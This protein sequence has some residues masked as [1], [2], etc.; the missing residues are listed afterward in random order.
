MKESNPPRLFVRFFRWFCHPE[1][2]DYVEGDLM[3]VYYRRRANAG[4]RKADFRFMIDVLLLLRP[5]IIR[6]MTDFRHLNTYSMYKSYFK[7]GWRNLMR[8]KGYALINIGGLSIG[9]TV[10]MLI[11]LWIWDEVSFDSFFDNRD[12]LA[13]VMINQS[14]EGIVYTG[15][16]IQMPLG[17]ALRTGY[18]SDFTG[19]SLA[20]WN[21]QF[22]LS[23]GETKLSGKGMWVQDEFPRMFTF[24]MLRGSYEALKDP[25]TVL[26][27]SSLARALFGN[28]D[29]VNRSLRVDS[30]MDLVVGGV[31]EDLP[32]NTT[33]HET[34]LLLPWENK[35]NWLN[36]QTDW[37]N[38]CGQLFVELRS[39]ADF[40]AVNEKIKGVPTPHI[41]KWKEE[42]MLHPMSKVHLYNHFEN[43]KAAG[44]RIQFI[45]LFGIIGVFVLL[46]ACIN[47]MNLSTARSERRAKEV[48]VRKTIGSV[49]SQIIGQFLCESIVVAG[50]AFVISLML[51]E[52][53]L[54][55]F[56]IQADKRMVVPWD[57]P[58]FWLLALGFTFSTGLIS[59]SYPAFYLSAFKP[60]KILKGVFT[61]GR[62]ALPRK[63]LVV[64]QF[65]VSITL[66]IGTLI[67]FRQVQHAKNRM[68][69][70]ARDGVI[71]VGI[72]TEELR[73]STAVIRN[74]LLQQ[75][76][77]E[78]MA[79]S[80]QSPA[81]FGNNNGI[82]WRGK[83][84]GLVVFFRNVGVDADFGKTIG[85]TVKRGRDFSATLPGD[86][87]AMVINERAAKVMGFED[88]L[89]E[90]VKF[91]G[92]EYTIIGVTQDMLTQSPYDPSEPT[93]F[94][95]DDWM[96]LI[97]MRLD[98]R[99][100]VGEA[101]AGIET[102]FKKY[103][104]ESP[105]DFSFVD[106][107]YARKY[108][109]EE[110]IGNLTGLFAALAIFISCLG[111]SGL[112]SFV[113]EQRT[114]EIGIR[115]VLGASA[116]SL[117]KMLSADFVILTIIAC[118]I[119]I[120]LSFAFMNS[121]LAQY[122]YRIALSWE[123]FTAPALGAVILTLMT[124]SYQ[125][126]KAVVANPV[127]SLRSE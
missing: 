10:A 1:I 36:T 64:V 84:P 3:E 99:V 101:L 124:V 86:S 108:S 79:L 50:L 52:V 2:V 112:A 20:S 47:F 19:V 42:I 110:R 119:S 58:V 63:V 120:P 71:T 127:R 22:V 74:E 40:N 24:N 91:R 125:A 7:I 13:Q 83:D 65:T 67:V 113:A 41:E 97:V 98:S 68:A 29:P 117:L 23:T 12:R 17:D 102:V 94:V 16:T 121:W 48:G 93:F 27:S 76:L 66:I 118:G 28:D 62:G 114:K 72:S 81:H 34:Q 39:E 111:L 15:G 116:A 32:Y 88:P 123:I 106:A 37:M 115:K 35:A 49:R 25:S 59:G 96:G 95:T 103:N 54:P 89:G 38:H 5:G 78:N 53:S 43:G 55:Y 70:F 109:N 9:M 44:G 26:I 45:W 4:K 6:P 21:N 61:A 56:N 46:L 85:W 69:G 57:M 31:Y 80:S 122:Q 51:V 33:F 60:V 87:S 82:D 90:I 11:G 18:A 92:K 77:I 73:K 107:D 30:R 75:G 105:F 100:P 8:N 126:V 104:P 14:H